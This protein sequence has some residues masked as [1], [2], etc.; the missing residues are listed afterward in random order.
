MLRFS[1]ACI[2]LAWLVCVMLVPS[3]AAG[4]DDLSTYEAAIVNGVV[5]N[6]FPAVGVLLYGST[7]GSAQLTCTGTLIGCQTFLTAA[8][9]VCDTVG[10]DCQ[11]PGNPDPSLFFVYLQNAGL[12]GVSSIAVR[13]DFNF[14]TG[15]VAVLK[16]SSQVTGIV[17]NRINTV[18]KPG[19]GMTGTIVGF[20]RTGGTNQDYG[21]KESGAVGMTSCSA[22]I[23]NTTSVCWNFAT[24]QGPAGTNSNTCNGDSGGPLFVDFGPG[25]VIAGITSGGSS[26]NCLPTDHSYDANVYNYRSWIEAQ[27]GT[28][29]NTTACGG[30][31][32]VGSSGVAVQSF[33]GSLAAGGG[34]LASLVVP[35]G[36]ALLRV[37]LNAVD[38]VDFYVKAGESAT[39]TVYDCKQ[40]GASPFGACQFVDPTPGPWS[41]YVLRYAGSGAYQLT[42]TRFG[43]DCSDLGNTGQSCDDGN[44]CTENDS[45]QM[46]RC[47]GTPTTDGTSCDDRNA[48]T[49]P[50]VCRAGACVGGASPAAN[51]ISSFNPV[52]G[53]I[54]LRE[55][56]TREQ[57]LSW[58]WLQGSATDKSAFGD[59]TSVTPY[60][61]CVYDQIAGVDSLVLQKQIVAG[62]FCGA[63]SCW[64]KTSRGFHY[65]NRSALPS[66]ISGVDLRS[67]ISGKAQIIVR[68]HG[69]GLA[70]PSLPL[71]QDAA[72]T[73][74]LNNGISCWQGRYSSSLSN[75]GV[76]FRATPSS[77]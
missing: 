11:G 58:R 33:T 43:N 16:L 13:P 32:V 74:Q 46:S 34:A 52:A 17:P 29:I 4:T 7:V 50:D 8:H 60:S 62:G 71:H 6:E 61:F 15:D 57:Q 23:S 38:D 41:V 5:T 31:P 12:F 28:D 36:T 3:L 35:R 26:D 54:R 69:P 72:V 21:I 48:C 24:P 53:S 44:D 70:L 19:L 67:G 37:T 30:L 22:G 76:E 40:D 14:P 59:P 64:R 10:S 1:V 18:A 77:P 75:T 20:G 25:P 55:P 66:G 47:V 45:C 73:V 51:C 68:G 65:G 49:N 27:A 42:A 63:R 9:C 56:P 39:S 2:R